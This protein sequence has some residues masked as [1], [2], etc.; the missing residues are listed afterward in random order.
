MINLMGSEEEWK[1][2][3]NRNN[4]AIFLTG[5]FMDMEDKVLAKTYQR[6]YLERENQSKMRSI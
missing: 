5:I 3:Y 4:L 1:E 2:I 6:G